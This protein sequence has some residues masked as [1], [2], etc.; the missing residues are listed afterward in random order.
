MPCS[1]TCHRP[2]LASLNRVNETHIAAGVAQRRL[3]IGVGLTLALGAFALV[4]TDSLRLSKPS[5]PL[6]LY[7]IPLLRIQVLLC[8]VQCMSDT[9]LL[10]HAFLR[11]L[12]LDQPCK[13][14]VPHV[15]EGGLH[16]AGS[17]DGCKRDRVG[18]QLGRA[19]R[20][21]AADTGHAQQRRVQ[22]AR[23]SIQCAPSSVQPGSLSHRTALAVAHVA[24][25]ADGIC[26]VVA[27]SWAAKMLPGGC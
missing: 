27:W 3:L 13:P 18:G 20:S 16:A 17:A 4:P 1:P 8:L 21:A 6:Y 15:P 7:L 24:V 2:C 11:A 26:G 10:P 19:G 5:R 23:R 12:G 9:C 22:P 25:Q 14:A